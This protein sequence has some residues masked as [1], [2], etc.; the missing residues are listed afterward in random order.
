MRGKSYEDENGDH[1]NGHGGTVDKMK[2]K[3]KDTLKKLKP[4]KTG[5]AGL[6]KETSRYVEEKKER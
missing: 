4:K 2:K 5:P 6:N 1:E 3:V